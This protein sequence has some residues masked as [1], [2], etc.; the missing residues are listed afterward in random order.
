V[1]GS[2]GAGRPAPRTHYDTLKVSRDAPIEVIRAAYRALVQLHH[3]DRR[4]DD[5][6]AMQAMVEINA[7]FD[8]LSD[9][10]RRAVYDATIA[11]LEGRGAE[12]RSTLRATPAAPAGA[13]PT[14]PA[15]DAAAA[16][17]AQA[18]RDRRRAR[19]RRRVDA[20]RTPDTDRVAAPRRWLAAASVGLAIGALVASLLWLRAQHQD[21]LRV[22]LGPDG[23]AV[24]RAYPVDQ[25][26]LPEPAVPHPEIAGAPFDAD[27]VSA[28]AAISAPVARRPRRAV[29]S[30][31]ASAPAATEE[32]ATTAATP[33]APEPAR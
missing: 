20:D 27:A 10:K 32:A 23:T 12:R 15:G 26:F 31:A 8:L 13:A 16:A 30:S 1:I 25:P 6:A 2:K 33:S 4:P 28:P 22:E 18:A 3:P 29:P 19:E 14:A 7:A 11:K 9:D 24:T 17:R 5:P 21:D